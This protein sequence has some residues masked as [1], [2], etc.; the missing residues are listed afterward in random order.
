MTVLEENGLKVERVADGRKCVEAV[1][2][3]PADYFDMILMDIQMP[4]LDGYEATKQIR[5]LGDSRAQIPI[6]AMTAN[7]FDEDRKK[8]LDVG[9][10]DHIAKPVDQETLF[11]IMARTIKQTL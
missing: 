1:R 3:M 7:A 4:G 11:E 9:M 5:H 10:N 2:K 8:A 6:I